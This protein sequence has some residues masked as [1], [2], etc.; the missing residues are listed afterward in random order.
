MGVGLSPL[1]LLALVLSVSSVRISEEDAL[2]QFKQFILTYNKQY[3]TPEEYQERFKIFTKNLEIAA[4][5]SSED[6]HA[7]YG[8][9]KFSD[10]SPEEFRDKYL[11]KNFTRASPAP[12]QYLQPKSNYSFDDLPP[13][14]DW[15]HHGVVTVVYNQ[16]QC[17]SCWFDFSLCVTET[18]EGFFSY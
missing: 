17:G 11:I 1:L 3:A 8:V 15:R 12:S 14:F 9:T 4:Q 7:Q 10:L 5:Y 6:P 13:S 16:G 18:I 2:R